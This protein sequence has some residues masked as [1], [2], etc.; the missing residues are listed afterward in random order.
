MLFSDFTGGVEFTT[1]RICKDDS[2]GDDDYLVDH[3]AED[4][5]ENADDEDTDK[6]KDTNEMFSVD[7]NQFILAFEKLRKRMFPIR[8]D[9][10]VLKRVC[11]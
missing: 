8:E 6:K 2:S 9:N 4:T 5:V 3:D 7:D 11:I 1:E 10:K